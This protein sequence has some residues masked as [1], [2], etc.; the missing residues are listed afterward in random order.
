MSIRP[1]QVQVD[2]TLYLGQNRYRKRRCR[3]GL[4]TP[5]A[6]TLRIGEYA[7]RRQASYMQGFFVTVCAGTAHREMK[8]TKVGL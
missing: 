5:I 6:T 7:A 1:I 3:I 4:F 2:L 8:M